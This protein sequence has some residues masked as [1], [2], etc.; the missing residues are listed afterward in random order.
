MDVLEGW[1][2]ELMF[3]DQFANSYHPFSGYSFYLWINTANH[4]TVVFEV[5]LLKHVIFCPDC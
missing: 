2:W 4:H 5:S 1:Q 3:A